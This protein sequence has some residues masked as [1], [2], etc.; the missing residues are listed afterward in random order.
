[1]NNKGLATIESLVVAPALV[2]LVALIFLS[3]YFVIAT[4]WADYWVYRA[5]LCQ[6]ISPHKHICHQQ[7][8]EKLTK[9]IPIN[10]YKWDAEWVTKKTSHITITLHFNKTIWFVSQATIN[11]PLGR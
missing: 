9:L 1:M 3:T 4:K 11:L 10:S 5:T 6:A 8:N 7:L 2:A